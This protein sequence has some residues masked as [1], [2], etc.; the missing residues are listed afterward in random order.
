MT[1]RGQCGCYRCRRVIGFDEQRSVFR[2]EMCCI[3]PRR[4]RFDFGKR[5][6]SERLY[7]P[8]SAACIQ[9]NLLLTAC[10]FNVSFDLVELASTA[11]LSRWH[12]RDLDRWL[13]ALRNSTTTNQNDQQTHYTDRWTSTTRDHDETII[14]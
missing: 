1:R 14:S 7:I 5:L 3:T 2:A 6:I 9:N 8:C 12:G 13:Y 11:F 4:V 10:A